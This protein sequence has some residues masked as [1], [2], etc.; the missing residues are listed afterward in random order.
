[1]KGGRFRPKERD[2]PTT[3]TPSANF[4]HDTVKEKPHTASETYPQA[5][6]RPAL[7]FGK[8]AG[9]HRVYTDRRA[10]HDYTM[11]AIMNPD[12]LFPIPSYYGR[13]PFP[14]VPLRFK[15]LERI[16]IPAGNTLAMDFPH[17]LAEPGVLD[18]LVAFDYVLGATGSNQSATPITPKYY[19]L[20]ISDCMPTGGQ[21]GQTARPYLSTSGSVCITVVRSSTLDEWPQFVYTGASNTQAIP[22]WTDSAYNTDT[23]PMHGQDTAVIASAQGNC[24]ST[25][26]GS[27]LATAPREPGSHF[28]AVLPCSLSDTGVCSLAYS[29]SCAGY[30]WATMFDTYNGSG[31]AAEC[32]RPKLAIVNSSSANAITVTIEVCRNVF[33]APTEQFVTIKPD[34]C[35]REC[36]FR[37][38][39][40]ALLLGSCGAASESH[41]QAH[42]GALLR[43]GAH[44]LIKPE[45]KP[46]VAHSIRETRTITK[47]VGALPEE[48]RADIIDHVLGGIKTTAKALATHGVTWLAEQAAP[49]LLELLPMLL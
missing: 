35:I 23:N 30:N 27:E 16:S 43:A 39:V 36:E 29:R 21:A 45:H 5:T 26:L 15:T 3:L 8:Y 13:L 10:Y 11:H 17:E 40:E 22:Q 9:P 32:S 42:A 4:G 19:P 37:F 1:M 44:P 20:K 41:H 47:G 24:I 12:K 18:H 48:P 49:A 25:V 28:Y 34:D 38:P 7:G 33:V 46:I 31:V 6:L 14:L 2:T